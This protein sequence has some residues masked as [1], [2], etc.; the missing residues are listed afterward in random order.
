M[1]EKREHQLSVNIFVHC[2]DNYLFLHRHPDK[3]I[4]P[5]L[6]NSIGG[7]VDPEENFVTAAIREAHEETGLTLVPSDLRFAGTV[8]LEGGYKKDWTMAWFRAE[9]DQMLPRHGTKVE[10]GTLLWIHKDEVLQSNYEGYVDDLRC[11]FDLVTQGKGPFFV[12]A[13]IGD[14]LKVKSYTIET[15]Q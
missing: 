12:N 5:N 4:D 1:S 6:K 13:Q 3:A 7:K 11:A 2:G 10:D 8:Q 15:L 14:D 9:V